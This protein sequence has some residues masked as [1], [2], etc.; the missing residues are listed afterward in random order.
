VLNI[1][2]KTKPYVKGSAVTLLSSGVVQAYGNYVYMGALGLLKIYDP[3][4]CEF[5]H[6]A[7]PL[8][9]P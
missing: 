1:A 8:A 9:K 3:A 5:E 2:D 6:H 7:R 4:G